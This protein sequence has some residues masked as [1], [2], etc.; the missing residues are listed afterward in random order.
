MAKDISNL[1]KSDLKVLQ[2]LESYGEIEA[3]PDSPSSSK[4][5][6]RIVTLSMK[7]GGL[8]D[9][10]LISRLTELRHLDISDNAKL[11]NISRLRKLKKLQVLN[12]QGC[13]K[14]DL[15][16]LRELSPL[17]NLKWFAIDGQPSLRDISGLVNKQSLKFLSLLECS[18]LDEGNAYEVLQTLPAL[19]FLDLRGGSITALPAEIVDK[20]GLVIAGL[21]HSDT[22]DDTDGT[23]SST[24]PPLSPKEAALWVFALVMFR[25]HYNEKPPMIQARVYVSGGGLEIQKGIVKYVKLDDKDEAVQEIDRCFAFFNQL[26]T[27]LEGSVSGQIFIMGDDENPM[28]GTI[29]L[30]DPFKVG[31]IGILAKFSKEGITFEAIGRVQEDDGEPSLAVY[32]LP[33]HFIAASLATGL[34]P[35]I[36]ITSND[37][38]A[39]HDLAEKAQELWEA[40]D[41]QGLHDMIPEAEVSAP[42]GGAIDDP[43]DAD[44]EGFDEDWTEEVIESSVDEDPEASTGIYMGIDIGKGKWVCASIEVTEDGLPENIGSYLVDFDEDPDFGPCFDLALFDVPIGLIPDSEAKTTASGGRSGDRP[45]DKGARKWC[46]STSSVFPPPTIG[47]YESGIAEHERSN[48]AGD[49]KRVLSNVS[50]KG[51]SQQGLE[52]IPA[53]ESAHRWKR[54]RPGQVFESHPEVIF[55][56]LA[57]G[58]IEH[59]KKTPEGIE[60]R[61]QILANHLGKLGIEIDV[62]QWANDK[63]QIFRVRNDDWIDALALAYTAFTCDSDGKRQ[64]LA[65]ASGTPSNW[66]G[67]NDQASIVLPA[68]RD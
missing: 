25:R 39:I 41:E 46:R 43:A 65:D 66:S 31:N 38:L 12:L 55:S 42:A 50:P 56:Y 16:D 36:L 3:T 34:Q 21:A 60:E 64:V 26:I 47:Q 15:T 17:S 30:S 62:A 49:R 51:L 27:N 1:K 4:D 33:D 8:E 59:S 68:C 37:P 57:D 35:D 5:T 13:P 61:S 10:K 20:P 67:H 22:D 45:V 14:L 52:M 6:R 29:D 63:A 40:E 19:T 7:N 23:R 58:K 24:I 48:E 54:T 53:I 11:V 44:S 9:A 32:K 2:A 28:A 18:S